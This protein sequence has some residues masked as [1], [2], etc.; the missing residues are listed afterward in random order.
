MELDENLQ[1]SKLCTVFALYQALSS[2]GGY[3]PR[4]LGNETLRYIYVVPIV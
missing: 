4:E 3:E 1:V 2:Q